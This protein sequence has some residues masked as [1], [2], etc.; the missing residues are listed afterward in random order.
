MEITEKELA[1]INEI[2][3]NHMPDQRSI[4]TRTGISLGMTNIIIKKLIKMGYIKSKQL[5]TR[6][7]QYLLTPKGFSE[8]AKKSY[9]FTIKTIDILKS[10]RE[11]IQHLIITEHQKGAEEFILLGNGELVEI[12]ELAF[13]NLKDIN[14][15]YSRYES[16]DK[17]ML[18]INK[19]NEKKEIDIVAYLSE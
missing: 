16:Q 15:K 11:K 2:A 8:K 19:N 18:V 1:V 10:M 5:T 3:N 6:K 13:R 7:I 17:V 14:V 9:N 4:A 12:V